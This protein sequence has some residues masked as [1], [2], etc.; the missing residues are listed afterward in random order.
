MTGHGAKGARGMWVV[1]PD[2][3]QDKSTTVEM[4]GQM[5]S[6]CMSQETWP[7]VKINLLRWRQRAKHAWGM[8]VENPDYTDKFAMMKV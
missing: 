5:Y 6:R 4:Q 2:P 3:R 1:K 7:A 8:W